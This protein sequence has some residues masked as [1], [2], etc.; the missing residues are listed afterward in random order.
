MLQRH[1]STAIK[2]D[3]YYDEIAV[4][5]HGGLTRLKIESVPAGKISP[6][7]FHSLVTVGMYKIE[8]SKRGKFGRKS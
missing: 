2:L 8:M 4:S 6:E 7:W 3:R 5:H 1:N